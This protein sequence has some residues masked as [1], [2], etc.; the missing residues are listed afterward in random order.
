MAVDMSLSE[1]VRSVAGAESS[2]MDRHGEPPFAA[3]EFTADARDWLL[4]FGMAAGLARTE[5]PCESIDDV[6]QR[7]R[8]AANEVFMALNWDSPVAGAVA[9]ELTPAEAVA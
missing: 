6:A 1:K 5:E 7:A 9:H 4:Y 8:G 2:L 3:S